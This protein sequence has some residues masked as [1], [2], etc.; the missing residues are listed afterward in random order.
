MVVAM[1]M[2]QQDPAMFTNFMATNDKMSDQQKQQLQQIVPMLG[3][4]MA[5]MKTM[6]GKGGDP[7]SNIMESVLTGKSTPLTS[8]MRARGAQGGAAGGNPFAP[9]GGAPANPGATGQ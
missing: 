7:M 8:M 5:V 9:R 6:S 4:S 2:Y 3:A 1:Q